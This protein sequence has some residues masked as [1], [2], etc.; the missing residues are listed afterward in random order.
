MG[1]DRTTDELGWVTARDPWL[2]NV[3]HT[4]MIGRWDSLSFAGDIP[5]AATGH[6]V[7][8]SS[9]SSEKWFVAMHVCKPFSWIH[10]VGLPR[11]CAFRKSLGRGVVCRLA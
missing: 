5:I 6:L 3:S 9:L 2:A 8:G 11:L 7:L 1:F 10:S 4:P